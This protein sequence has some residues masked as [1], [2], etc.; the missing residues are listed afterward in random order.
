MCTWDINWSKVPKP[1]LD[2]IHDVGCNKIWLICVLYWLCSD[3]WY[4]YT[5]LFY[6]GKVDWWKRDLWYWFGDTVHIFYTALSVSDSVG[7]MCKK[8]AIYYQSCSD[9]ARHIIPAVYL[10]CYHFTPT[11]LFQPLIKYFGFKFWNEAFYLLFLLFDITICMYKSLFC[12]NC[13]AYLSWFLASSFYITVCSTCKSYDILAP[14]QLIPG[15]MQFEA[16]TKH[17]LH[18]SH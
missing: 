14:I 13:F 15:P 6:I 10:M 17:I 9:N 5:M 4:N 1:L 8:C 2:C 7:V 12:N 3:P 18:I 11:P 16:H